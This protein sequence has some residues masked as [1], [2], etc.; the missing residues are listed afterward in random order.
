M[1]QCEDTFRLPES[2]LAKD[3]VNQPLLN[4]VKK[5]KSSYV[6]FLY[7]ASSHR[8]LIPALISGETFSLLASNSITL[9]LSKE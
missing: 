6:L 7:V 5:L 4:A 2:Q 8:A 3:D 9:N 1:H